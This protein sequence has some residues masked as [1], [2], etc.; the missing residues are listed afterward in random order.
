MSEEQNKS[1]QQ[2][3]S[4]EQA[5]VQKQGDK[6]REYTPPTIHAV[7]IRKDRNGIDYAVTLGTAHPDKRGYGDLMKM[8]SNTVSGFHN[9]MTDKGLREFRAKTQQ[10]RF[11]H[12]NSDRSRSE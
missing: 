11:E 3:Q 1:Q 9:V 6:K 7:D 12:R 10:E 8:R 4:Q 5:P 2:G